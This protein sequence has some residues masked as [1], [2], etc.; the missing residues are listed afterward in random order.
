MKQ[1]IGH[2]AEEERDEIRR[3]FE[4]RNGLNE[5]AKILSADNTD[6]YEKLIA[7]MG[8][9]YIQFQKW[10]NESAT[11]YHWQGADNGHWEIDFNSCE[12]FLV[13]PD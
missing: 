10:W 6:L 12:I 11:K 9:T 3:L 5:L 7:D 8:E 1:L 4:R 13:T 2:V